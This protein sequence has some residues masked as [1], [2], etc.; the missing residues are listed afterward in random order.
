MSQSTGKP[1]IEANSKGLYT[2]ILINDL[3]HIAV[4]TSKV[5]GYQ[6]WV[7][8]ESWYCIEIYTEDSPILCEYDTRDTWATILELL[9]KHLK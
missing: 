4:L 1:K 9:N 5:T 8:S 3:V 7:H 6:A 2:K